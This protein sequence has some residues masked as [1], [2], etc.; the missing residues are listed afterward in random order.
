VLPSN[1]YKD[2][3]ERKSGKLVGETRRKA[4]KEA[5]DFFM[6]FTKCGFPYAI[7]NPIGIMSTEYRKPDQVIQPWMFGHTE[8]KATCLWLDGLPPLV[9]TKTVLREM[10]QLPN[11]ERQRLHHLSNTEERSKLRSKT[12]PNIAAAMAKQWSFVLQGKKY[13]LF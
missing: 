4:R 2:Q 9:R 10:M 3:P 12:Y 11:K 7:E 1:W 8:Q 6:R 5:I 13:Y